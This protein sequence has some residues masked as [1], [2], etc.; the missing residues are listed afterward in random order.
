MAESSDLLS[1]IAS[2]FNEDEDTSAGVT[3]RL[4]KIVIKRLST[5]HGEEKL[6]EKLGQYLRPDKTR[7]SNGQY[8]TS[9]KDG[10]YCMILNLK[11]FNTHVAYYHFKMDT[12]ASAINLMKPHC[13]MASV[14]LKDAYYSVPVSAPD[15]KYLKFIW[16]GQLFPQWACILPRLFTELLKPVY[17]SLG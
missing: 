14:N 11:Q 16:Y 2:D 13:F 1:Q 12:L 15:Q 3:E 17:A 6:K 8:L 9:K 4:A 5:P 10:S 7:S